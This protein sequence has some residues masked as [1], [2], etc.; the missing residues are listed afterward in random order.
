MLEWFTQ[1]QIQHNHVALVSSD[2]EPDTPDA[3]NMTQ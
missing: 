1:Y 3:A 2:T